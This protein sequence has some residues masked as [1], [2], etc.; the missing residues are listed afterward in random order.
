[1]TQRL[2]QNGTNS[3]SNAADGK[4]IFKYAV[5]NMNQLKSA[6]LVLQDGIFYN[7]PLLN[8]TFDFHC[9]AAQ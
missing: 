8:K 3:L 4:Q 7:L 1:V 6:I 9:Q 2:P 5:K